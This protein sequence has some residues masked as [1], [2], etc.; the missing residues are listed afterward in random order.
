MGTNPDATSSELLALYRRFT[1][2]QLR[3]L[4]DMADQQ[5]LLEQEFADELQT[6]AGREPITLDSSGAVRYRVDCRS[7]RQARL[8]NETAPTCSWKRDDCGFTCQQCGA[9]VGEQMPGGRT[10]GAV[11]EF[12]QEAG[13]GVP[14]DIA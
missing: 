7:R 14:T 11:L 13:Q 12:A 6:V 10:L 1:P 3:A 2:E 4:A 5:L 9:W 8:R